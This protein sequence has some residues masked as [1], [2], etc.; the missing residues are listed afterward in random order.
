LAVKWPKFRP[1]VEGTAP[2]GDTLCPGPICTI[3]QKFTPIGVTLAE[4]YVTGHIHR[5]IHRL[6]ADLISD[7][8]HTSVGFVG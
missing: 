5:Y 3:M 2:K 1:K 8:T 6:T 7:K 4:I